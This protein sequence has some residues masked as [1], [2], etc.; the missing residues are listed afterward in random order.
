MEST[1]VLLSPSEE[2]PLLGNSDH[3]DDD[4]HRGTL[5]RS[6]GD[7]LRIQLND[8]EVRS[9]R[10]SI[11]ILHRFA[12]SLHIDCRVNAQRICGN[13]WRRKWKSPPR[14]K[15]SIRIW[16][17]KKWLVSY[18]VNGRLLFA[19]DS[20]G[21]SVSRWKQK[22]L[23]QEFLANEMEDKMREH[24][25]RMPCVRLKYFS[26]DSCSLHVKRIMTN[27]RV[28]WRFWQCRDKTANRNETLVASK[29]RSPDDDLLSCLCS[30]WSTSIHGYPSV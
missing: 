29:G 9:R 8:G 22:D 14:R 18:Q 7:V 27:L 11:E 3:S 13:A 19:T 30:P 26:A 15:T 25:R 5:S 12:F 2:T 20:I 10:R 23:S 28:L 21:N 16:S 24:R 17:R 1:D 6:L 4:F